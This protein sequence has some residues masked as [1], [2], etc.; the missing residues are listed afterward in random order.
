MNLVVFE[1]RPFQVL[2][3]FRITSAWQKK[4]K[5]KKIIFSDFFFLFVKS[6]QNLS[7]R[8]MRNTDNNWNGLKWFL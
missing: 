8:V 3:V 7:V 6:A 2:S 4:K 5:V 1:I